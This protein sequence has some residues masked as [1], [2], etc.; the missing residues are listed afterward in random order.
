MCFI[1]WKYCNSHLKE[2]SISLILIKYPNLSKST[3][4]CFWL[5][6]STG[7][8]L[9]CCPC[10]IQAPQAACFLAQGVPTPSPHQSTDTW[11]LRSATFSQCCNQGCWS[12]FLCFL[13]LWRFLIHVN[14]SCAITNCDCGSHQVFL[15]WA[16]P[17]TLVKYRPGVHL[18]F[19]IW[20]CN[21]GIK[22]NLTLYQWNYR[23]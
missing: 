18:N 2:F 12:Y 22:N 6:Q 16:A 23:K 11:G 21:V 20:P 9:H 4:S 1:I 19:A 7:P 3:G 14:G 5:S 15:N 17:P 13:L 10:L 8:H